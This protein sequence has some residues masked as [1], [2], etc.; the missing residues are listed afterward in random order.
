MKR[1][2]SAVFMILVISVFVGFVPTHGHAMA[3]TEDSE[4]GLSPQR[5]SSDLAP[6]WSPRVQQ[7]ESLIA[8]EAER[9]Q[10]DPDF[11]ASLA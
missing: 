2:I 1:L 10:L 6:Y 11:L 7:W 3:A 9:R 8:Q 5:S 4:G